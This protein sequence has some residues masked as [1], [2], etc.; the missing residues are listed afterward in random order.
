[1]SVAEFAAAAAVGSV[2]HLPDV[3]RKRVDATEGVST[4][5]RFRWRQRAPHGSKK[6]KTKKNMQRNH[7]CAS[8][9]FGVM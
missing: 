2:A 1:L 3:A 6:K 8:P 9:F 5:D 7:V 4:S